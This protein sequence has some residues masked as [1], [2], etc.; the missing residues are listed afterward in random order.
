MRT[1]TLEMIA[2]ELSELLKRNIE[3]GK[4]EPAGIVAEL[5]AEIH[6]ELRGRGEPFDIEIG[7]VTRSEQCTRF[8]WDGEKQ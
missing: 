1:E 8:E 6:T 7:I 4:R 5:L 3:A 2:M